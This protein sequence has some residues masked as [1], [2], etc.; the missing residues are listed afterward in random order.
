MSRNYSTRQCFYTEDVVNLLDDFNDSDC[1]DDE[2]QDF[3]DINDPEDADSIPSDSEEDDTISD[4]STA[5]T[6]AQQPDAPSHNFRWRKVS[7]PISNPQ[8]CGESFPPPPDIEMTPYDYFKIFFDDDLMKNI[9]FQ[10]NLYSVQNEST[11]VDVSSDE[12][13]QYIGILVNMAIVRCPTLEMYWSKDY[14]VPCVADIM[15]NNRFNAIK[16]NLHFNDNTEAKPKDDPNYDKLFKVRPVV[17]SVLSKCQS[18]VPEPDNSVDEQI[19]PTKC[20][21]SLR[22]YMPKKPHKW[23]IKIWA[24]CGISGMLCNF[25]VYTGR[26]TDQRDI[27]GILMGGNVVY[28]LTRILPKER[29][30]KV[31]FDN[32]FSSLNLMVMLKEEKIWAIATIRRDRLQDAGPK[33]AA[34]KE[35]KKKGRGAMDHITDANSG[36]CVV[37]WHDNSI[38]QLV[39]NY[40]GPSLGDD[41]RRWSKKDKLFTQVPCPKMVRE[42][43]AHMGGV[44][45]CDMLLELYRVRRRT[46]K[47]YMHI[48]YYCVG[49]SIVNGWLLY[50]RHMDQMKV[51]KKKQ[52]TLLKFHQGIGKGLT[53]ANKLPKNIKKRGRPSSNDLVPRLVRRPPMVANPD[54]ATRFDKFCHFADVDKAQHRCR[55]CSKHTRVKCIKCN[56]FLCQMLNRNCFAKYHGIELATLTDN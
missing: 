6:S 20:R 56:V 13:E 37:K 41:V 47:S 39:S 26:G 54:N 23:G 55:E 51:P 29:N 25:E 49:V 14:R 34:D 53:T 21:T 5:S 1:T 9:A 12:I 50:R 3:P 17:D 28:R 35:L 32:Y 44:D 31:F 40:S 10:T 48:F 45:L 24:F 36:V 4:P 7:P 22:Q 42:Y 46:V 27:P 2:D 43:N 8:F 30:Y 33:L 15:D 18:M 38:V 16:K 19:V 52:K 11:S